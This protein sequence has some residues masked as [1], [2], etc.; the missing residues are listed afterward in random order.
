MIKHIF[1]L[2]WNQRKSNIWLLTELLLV[3]VC[4]WYVVDFMYVQLRMYTAPLGFNIEHTYRLDLSERISGSNGYIS[5]EKKTTT[6]GEDLLFIL[7]RI[8]KYP[9][10]E[11]ASISHSSQ[12]Y[13][14]TD[15]N[16]QLYSDTTGTTV[17]RYYVSEGF[18]DVFRIKSKR[19]NTH[20]LKEAFNAQ[21]IILSTDA[22]RELFKGKSALGKTVGYNNPEN[23]I[24]ISAISAPV[25]WTEF[26]K[27]NPCFYT[28][29]SNADMAKISPEE[30]QAIEVSVRV[31]PDMDTDFAETFIK[32]MAS[33]LVTGNIYLLDVRPVSYMREE[34][35]QLYFNNIKTRA[36]LLGFF[37]INIFLGVTGTFWFRSQHRRNEMGLRVAVGSTRSGLKFVLIGEGLILLTLAII[38]AIV[39]CFNIGFSEVIDTSWMDFTLARFWTGI[40][41]TYCLMALMIIAGIW[42][43]A[44]QIAAIEPAEAL[45]Y[46]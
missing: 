34:A 1:K 12:P 39:I 17:Q 29:F 8:R 9:A 27:S 38:P 28:F 10:V 5:P 40:G 36:I 46:E 3:S 31:K 23:K 32:D 18:F 22:E 11:A 20:E 14:G 30:V 45:H 7:E 24:K 26:Q 13:C 19:G 37:L 21:S 44:H 16:A 15:Q 2:I 35:V 4:L 33:Q 43:P 41:I 25:R 6:S 42:Y